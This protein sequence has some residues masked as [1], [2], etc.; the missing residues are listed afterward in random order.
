[1]L[2]MTLFET[3]SLY[4]PKDRQTDMG[5]GDRNGRREGER[6]RKNKQTKANGRLGALEQGQYPPNDRGEGRVSHGLSLSRWQ[7]LFR[8]KS[9]G[10]IGLDSIQP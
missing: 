4:L 10:Q 2:H 9:E 5:E 1:M 8:E 3:S 7:D 6:E